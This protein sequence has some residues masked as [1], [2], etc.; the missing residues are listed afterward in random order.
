[1]KIYLAGLVSLNKELIQESKYK[2]ES[3]FYIKDKMKPFLDNNFLLD[4]GAFTFMNSNKKNKIDW[5]SYID[6]YINYINLNNIKYF[7]ELDL[8]S[9]IGY[10]EV[11]KI[12][13]YIESKTNKQ[14]IPVWHKDR[15]LDCW[16]GLI[17][18]Y[19]YVSVGGIVS[20]EITKKNFKYLPKLINMAKEENTKVHGLGFTWVDYL[21]YVKFDTV[22]STYWNYGNRFGFLFQFQNGKMNEIDRPR[23]TRLTKKSQ[24][25]NYYEWIKFQK[26]ADRNL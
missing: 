2:L 14:C 19:N 9:I 17:K 20:K 22:D 6:K 24:I 13:K 12:T 10:N 11:K 4:S 7:F 25:H 5:N 23:N 26:Y 8:D 18:D 21:E 16:K 3:F 15:G 1:M